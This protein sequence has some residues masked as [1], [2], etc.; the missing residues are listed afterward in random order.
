MVLQPARASTRATSAP[1]VPPPATSA[2]ERFGES[3]MIGRPWEYRRGLS[4][5]RRQHEVKIATQIGLGHTRL[6]QLAVAVIGHFGERRRR[7]PPRKARRH[8]A[9]GDLKLQA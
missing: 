3:S 1:M 9:F 7:R 2:V 8:F 4:H 5:R 6:V